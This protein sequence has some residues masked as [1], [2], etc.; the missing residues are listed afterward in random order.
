M[1]LQVGD[2]REFGLSQVG[3]FLRELL[4]CSAVPEERVGVRHELLPVADELG[5]L[6]SEDDLLLNAFFATELFEL[7]ELYRLDVEIQ[8]PIRMPAHL[9]EDF[10][11]NRDMLAGEFRCAE[12]ADVEF[13]DF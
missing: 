5:M 13:F 2:A 4:F 12:R 10:C 3:Y 11:Q 6:R 1:N 8:H 7:V 9:V